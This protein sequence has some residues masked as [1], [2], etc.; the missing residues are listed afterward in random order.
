MS[1]W[2]VKLDLRTD[3]LDVEL[4][5]KGVL[6]VYMTSEEMNQILN[7]LLQK[8]SSA[9]KLIRILVY[10]HKWR[11]KSLNPVVKNALS[12]EILHLAR[13]TWIKFA[14]KELVED[15]KGVLWSKI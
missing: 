9:Q 2:P 4:Q 5:P 14:Q 11:S 3:H 15:L 12:V 13:M 10:V 6:M 7:K 8:C 1:E